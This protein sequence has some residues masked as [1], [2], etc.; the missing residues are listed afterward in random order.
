MLGGH[1]TALLGVLAALGQARVAAR[2]CEAILDVPPVRYGNAERTNRSG[3]IRLVE[4]SA[5]LAGF[6]ALRGVDVD[7]AAGQHVALVGS[8]DSG[9]SL[10]AAM[11]GRLIEPDAG[12]I[13]LD[14]VLLSDL[15]AEA[16]HG[17]VG[18][19]FA[20][21]ALLGRTIA[22]T[23]ALGAAR[24][25]PGAVVAAARDARADGFIRRLPDGYLTLLADAPM[26]GGEVQRLGLARAFA[27]SGDVLVF[28]DATSSLDTVTEHLVMEALTAGRARTRLVLTSRASTA[29]RAERVLWFVEGRVRRDGTHAELWR[30]PAYR[31]LFAVTG[32]LDP[33]L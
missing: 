14:G 29:A 31:A 25:E 22:G 32:G 26:S 24:P 3:S 17:T 11:L 18:F 21:P 4:V 10:I 5:N 9:V 20:R 15:T 7:I 23:I 13:L 6:P 8:E 16:L 2:R 28:D 19:A 1:A 27:H 30:D 33:V 12:A